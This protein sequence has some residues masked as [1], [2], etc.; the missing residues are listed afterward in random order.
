MAYDEALA[1]R[2]RK[3]LRNRHG[4]TE[5]KMFGGIAFMLRGHMFAGILDDTLMARVG[6]QNYERALSENGVRKMDFTGR[7]MRGY[8][9]VEAQAV[10]SDADLKHRLERCAEFVGTLPAKTTK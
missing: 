3:A 7:P 1:E 8:V 6:P 4:V 2:I 9:F 10:Q 5:R